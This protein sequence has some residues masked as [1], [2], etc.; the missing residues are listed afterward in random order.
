MSLPKLPDWVKT[1]LLQKIEALG[2]AREEVKLKRIFD[3]DPV[4]FGKAGDP[5]REVCG[6]HW[7][8][9]KRRT[10]QSYTTYLTK[11][12]PFG[13]GTQVELQEEP[14]APSPQPRGLL[15]V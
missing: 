11:K 1:T 14:R 5:I 6:N 13:A 9:L 3:S 10:I 12:V 8:N 2:Q 15:K 4:T 7:R